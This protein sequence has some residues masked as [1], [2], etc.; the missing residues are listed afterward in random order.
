MTEQ[1]AAAVASDTTS[2][3]GRLMRHA[4]YAAVAVASGLVLIKLF[5]YVMTGSVALLSSLID[6]ALDSAASIVNLIAVR[7]ALQPPTRSTALAM[8]RRSRW[9]VWG[10][11][12]SSQVRLSFW[13]LKPRAVFG[14]RSLS[15]RD[16]QVSP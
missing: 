8:A 1:T 10:R 3:N 6:S 14:I 15:H 12:P 11:R 13:F 9:L 7:Q 4:T 5:A 16:G 2:Q